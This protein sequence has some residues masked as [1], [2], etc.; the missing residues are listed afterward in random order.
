M[1]ARHYQHYSAACLALI[2]YVQALAAKS[3]QPPAAAATK[4]TDPAVP[5]SV[6][7]IDYSTG[8]D[9]FFPNSKRF[10]PKTNTVVAVVASGPDLTLKGVSGTN[11]RKLAIINNR[12]FEIGEEGD[13]KVNGQTVR[14]KCVEIRTKS[15]LIKQNGFDRELF[16]GNPR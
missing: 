7:V 12:T 9:P 10:K 1:R 8:K 11:A 14:V 16:L 3:A 13:I 5:Q 2:F 6:F 15:V 4:E